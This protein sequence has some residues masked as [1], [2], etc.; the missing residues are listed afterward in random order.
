MQSQESMMELLQRVG[1]AIGISLVLTLLLMVLYQDDQPLQFQPQS[2][3]ITQAATV[4]ASGHG[5]P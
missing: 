4:S 2:A 3:S 5:T 1:V